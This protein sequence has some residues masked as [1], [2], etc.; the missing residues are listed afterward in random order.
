M[1]RVKRSTGRQGRSNAPRIKV[2]QLE[3]IWRPVE[4]IPRFKGNCPENWTDENAVE[5]AEELY[6]N[7]FSDKETYQSV[8]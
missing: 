1:F 2:V 4:L 8:Y 5:L 7:S 6:V 3:D